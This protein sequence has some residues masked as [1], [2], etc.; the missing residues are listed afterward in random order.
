LESLYSYGEVGVNTRR[1]G[2]KGKHEPIEDPTATTA[3]IRAIPEVRPYM[4]DSPVFPI[5]ALPTGVSAA[6]P[7]ETVEGTLVFATR[8][9]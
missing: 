6:V 1:H 9:L 2:V 5:E 8:E 3:S 7:E 4:V